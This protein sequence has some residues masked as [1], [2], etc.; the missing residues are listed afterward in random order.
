MMGPLTGADARAYR[1]P[2]TAARVVPSAARK[3]MKVNRRG[4]GT[5]PYFLSCSMTAF[6]WVASGDVGSAAITFSIILIVPS[7]SPLFS[8]TSA[9]LKTG[10]LL[11]ETAATAFSY[12]VAASSVLPLANFTSPR[13]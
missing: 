1:Q 13:L 10:F 8:A 12:H 2:P 7:L 9:S 6:A 4:R 11:D 3:R 5:D